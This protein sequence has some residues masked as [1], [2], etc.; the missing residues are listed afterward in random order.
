MLTGISGKGLNMPANAE[1]IQRPE[2]FGIFCIIDPRMWTLGH[3]VGL[4]NGFV[5]VRPSVRLAI[6][7]IVSYGPN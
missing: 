4:W 2:Y 3:K 5:S 1:K 6:I 7:L